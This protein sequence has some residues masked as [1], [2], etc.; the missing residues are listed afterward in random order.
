MFFQS[1]ELVYMNR[2]LVK[3]LK[4]SGSKQVTKQICSISF[5]IQKQLVSNLFYPIFVCDCNLSNRVVKVSSWMGL[6]EITPLGD[7]QEAS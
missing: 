6:P 1:G 3:I 7:L 2:E 4:N 5:F